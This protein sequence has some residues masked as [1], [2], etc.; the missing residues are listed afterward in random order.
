MGSSDRLMGKTIHTLTVKD[1]IK[2][3]FAFS[4]FNAFA[5]VSLPYFKKLETKLKD[6]RM[7]EELKSITNQE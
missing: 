7:D 6:M 5:A 4:F 2:L 1:A 3:Y